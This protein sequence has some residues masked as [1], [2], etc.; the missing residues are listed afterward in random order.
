M[1]AFSSLILLILIAALSMSIVAYSNYLVEKKKRT[2]LRLESM[3]IRVEELEDV[4]LILDGLCEKRAIPKL[5][6]DEIIHL[7]DMMIEINPKAGYLQAGLSNAQVRSN[8]LSD[9]SA[10]RSI[11]RVCKSDAQIARFNAY[12]AEALTIIR[13]QHTEGKTTGQEIQNFTL[14]IQWLQLQIKVI[15]NIV[16][17]HKAYAKQNVLGANAFYKKAQSDL[18]QTS[19]PDQRRH[20][21][22]S[23]MAEILHGHRK[24]LDVELM[25]EAEFNPE[26]TTQ[27][28]PLSDEEQA[29][30]N[31][32]SK[33]GGS[34]TASL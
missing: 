21:M 29:M 3:K 13:K 14:E 10:H 25:P 30:M 19:H 34:P 4:V 22:I 17:G 2:T 20:Q 26:I 23:Q 12:L 8:E 11:S 5:I 28:A 9:E 32:Q 27:E 18:L 6:N 1:D 7:Y 16:Q 33:N 15:T 24:F 31:A